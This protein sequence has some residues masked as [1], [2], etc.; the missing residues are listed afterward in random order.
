MA[1]F[2]LRTIALNYAEWES[3]GKGIYPVFSK[4]D[5]AA[6]WS[7]RASAVCSLLHADVCFGDFP[8]ACDAV[9]AKKTS[10]KK[11]SKGKSL[12]NSQENE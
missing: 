7:D 12:D 2:L 8:A 1:P 5:D 9:V 6:S 11:S 4:P 10:D 3:G